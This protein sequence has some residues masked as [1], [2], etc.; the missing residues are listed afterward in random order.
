M[1]DFKTFYII[2][3]ITLLSI[4]VPVAAI[5]RVCD[6]INPYDLCYEVIIWLKIHENKFCHSEQSEKSLCF[7]IQEDIK[8]NYLELRNADYPLF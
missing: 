5:L 6:I 7:A 4:V 2:I 8:S 3:A 1:L